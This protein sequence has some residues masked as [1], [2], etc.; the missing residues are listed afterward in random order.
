METDVK[1]DTK[2]RKHMEDAAAY[3]AKHED[4]FSDDSTGPQAL[5]RSSD[6][7][8]VNKGAV[9]PKPCLSPMEMRTLTVVNGLPPAGTVSAATVAI[10][11]QPSLWFCLTEEI[12]LGHQFST[13]RTTVG[14]GR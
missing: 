8:P 1:P 4:S 13:Q 3:Q 7:A 10:F 11:H 6:K 5:S 9:A 12:N 14:F 2:T